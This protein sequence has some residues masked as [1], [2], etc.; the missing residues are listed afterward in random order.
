MK[1]QWFK[2]K[3]AEISVRMTEGAWQKIGLGTD[4]KSPEQHDFQWCENC[5]ITCS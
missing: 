5:E 4:D 1:K 3:V 2:P